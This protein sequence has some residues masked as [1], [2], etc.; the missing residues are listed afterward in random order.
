MQESTADLKP[1]T[2]SEDDPDAN[3]SF[4]ADAESIRISRYKLDL[5]QPVCQ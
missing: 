5:I 4:D 2:E 1:Q 3:W